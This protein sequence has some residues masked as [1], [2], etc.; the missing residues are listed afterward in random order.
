MDKWRNLSDKYG[1][2]LIEDCAQAHLTSWRGNFAGTFGD[3][4]TYSFYPTKNLG[5]LGDAGML[6][7]NNKGFAEKAE[8]I[9]NYGQSIRYHHPEIGMNSRL[10]EI[11]AAILIER[12]KWLSRFNERKKRIAEF[13]KQGIQNNLIMKM[14]DPEELS[15]HNYHQFVIMCAERNRFQS[16]LLNHQIETLI[17]YPIPIHHQKP[18]INIKRDPKGLPVSERHANQ[19][20]SLPCHPHLK[21]S[22]INHVIDSINSFKG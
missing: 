21:D 18:C 12:L 8:C 14:I 9:R 20:V 15:A 16:H 6:V 1:L 5:A 17:H 4:G 19:C 3:M 11:Q 7:T 10:D 22:E 2:F 13:Y